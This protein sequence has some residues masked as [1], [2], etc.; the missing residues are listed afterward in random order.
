MIED[1]AMHSIVVISIKQEYDGQAKQAAAIAV[2]CNATAMCLRFV[3][4]VDEDIDPFD[5]SQVLWALGTRC[6]PETS[7]DIIRGC[8]TGLTDPI[9]S[10][11]KRRLD[12]R[13]HSV[14]VILACKPYS[15]IKEFPSS[16]ESSPE[17]RQ[18]I[19]AK[20]KELFSR[21]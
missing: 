15:W 2:G 10:P 8:W 20:W 13:H 1:A 21:A 5:T 17:L 14:G 3:I 9:L 7:I 18:R 4:V 12:I 6:E 16:I 19:K 11:E